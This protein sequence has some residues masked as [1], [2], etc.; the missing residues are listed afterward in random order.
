MRGFTPFIGDTIH[1]VKVSLIEVRRLAD[2]IP[3]MRC[4]FHPVAVAQ[5][6]WPVAI[7]QLLSR[8]PAELAT[9][10]EPIGRA[11]F[12]GRAEKILHVA[13]GSRMTCLLG[14]SSIKNI[15]SSPS[16]PSYASP[17]FLNR[18]SSSSPAPPSSPSTFAT[19][20]PKTIPPVASSSSDDSSCKES[21]TI[22]DETLTPITSLELRPAIPCRVRH[23]RVIGCY[24][25]VVCL[26]DNLVRVSQ[27]T[28][29]WNPCI[30]KLK[31]LPPPTLRSCPFR[32]ILGFGANP[33]CADDLKVVRVVF[34]GTGLEI[35][36]VPQDVEIFSV[37]TGKWRRI[38]AAGANLHSGSFSSSP[39][40][41][42]HGALHWSSGKWLENEEYKQYITVFSMADEIFGEL[43][44]PDELAN[45]D[46]SSLNIME[47]GETI[48]VVKY[49]RYGDQE[50]HGGRFCEMWM[51][52][53]YGVVESWCRL[54]HIE[55]VPWMQR[56]VGI[57]KNGDLLISTNQ[58][59]L[60]SYCHNTEGIHKL[61][62][63]GSGCSYFTGK[64]L[65]S[66][67]LIQEQSCHFL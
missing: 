40:T 15:Y 57:R 41:F 7:R 18:C 34:G 26:S 64:Y 9:R 27:I 63:Y 21:Y 6:T 65:E 3:V 53:E 22:L 67:V 46:A 38:S 24:N 42:A 45:D 51:M 19:P 56:I 10:A 61:G 23:Y 1:I 47:F 11:E 62:I 52:K 37:I 54:H 5:S 55:L 4:P 31:T 48:V 43:M 66:L 17:P 44:L 50:I 39:P 20:A 2:V 13:D 49:G 58:E 59:E 12:M 33:E 8:S 14:S 29:L 25:G 35:S 16:G 30:Q 28:H 36:N 32:T 60:V